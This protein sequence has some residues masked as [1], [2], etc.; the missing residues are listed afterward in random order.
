MVRTYSKYELSQTFGLVASSLSNIVSVADSSSRATGPGLAVVGAN[1]HVLTWDIKKGQLVSRW[2]DVNTSAQVT[3][4][5]KSG[6]DPDIYAV[7][8]DDGTIKVWDSRIES[9]VI[10]FNGHKSAVTT[11]AFDQSGARLASGAKD[12]DIIIWDLVAEVGL[13]KLRGHKDQV[14][15]LSWISSGESEEE[16]DSEEQ[17][18]EEYSFI[19]SASKDATIKFWDV[20]SQH[21]LE[22]HVAQSNGE[23]WAMGVT[24]DMSGC[25]TA[26][27]DGEL[28]V[29]S[30]NVQAA[31]FTHNGVD[32][33]ERP[34]VLQDRGIIFRQSKERTTGVI[35]H[36][37]AD[38]FAVYGSEKAVEVWRIRSETEVQ[39]SMQRKK[40]RKREKA[41][42]TNGDDD[43]AMTNGDHEEDQ[44]P[45]ITEYFVPYTIVRTGG[46][47][48]AI[49]WI[50][51]KSSKMVQL[52]AACGNNSIE[53]YDIIAIESEKRKAKAE[54]GSDYTRTYSI[55]S[56]GHRTDVRAVSLSS[57]DRM[58]ATASSGLL[59][60]WNVKTGACLRTLD[61]G[62]ALC[63]AFLPGDK[64]VVVG[65]KTGEIE[66]F[67]IA[68][69]TLIESI[70]A[71]EASIWSLQVHPDGKSCV[72]GGADKTAKFWNFDIVQEDI[73]GTKRTTP[74]LKLTHT[75]SLKVNDD[76][77]SLCFSPDSRLLAVATLDNTVKVFFTDTLKLFLNLYGHR[78]PAISMSISS[79]SKLIATSSADKN[80]RLWGL[81][82]GDCH[83]ALF[84]HNDSI[85]NV[86]FIQE[87]AT[88]EEG[89]FFFSAS[90][91]RSVKTWD[92]DKFEQVQKLSGHHSE[93]WALAVSRTGDFFVTA[94]HDKSIRIWN[95]TDEPI[96]L[97]E[98]RERE[99]EE[100]YE[101]TLTTS[102]D[103]DD[104]DGNADEDA[105]VAASKQT[106]ATLT[107]GEKIMEA[108]E[109]G[110]EDL[111][112]VQ[113][114]E[115]QKAVNPKMAPPQRD[116][117]FMALGFISA[118]RHVLNTFAKIP[119]AQL[120]DALLVLPFSVLPA[121]LTFIS[122]WVTKQRDVTLVCRVL[123]FMIKTHQKQIVTSRELKASLETI[124][125]ELRATLG[126]VKDVLGFNLAAL[127]C[128]EDRAREKG[129]STLEDV[130]ADDVASSGKKRAFVDIG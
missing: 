63:C 74:R 71:H 114:W 51:K 38:Y 49:D 101:S 70:Q 88:P 9:I 60:I 31:Q 105:A 1:E 6:A 125:R 120:Q 106:V 54:E 25:I 115:R 91:D 65:T 130:E 5:T 94:S 129:I 118:E 37:K 80:I 98:E 35:F 33:K 117:L 81:D 24:P 20:A 50:D 47:V 100:L 112:T 110:M 46:K 75:R 123:F 95:L 67:D 96:F 4:L 53:V 108:L 17:T 22:T 39:K 66:L 26:G 78:L 124:R 84:G 89:H 62:Y 30:V 13:F 56:P 16:E 34:R 121:L 82:F 113:A 27:N 12:T 8:Y 19:L 119:A 11:L 61:C 79:D 99:M 111:A 85:M 2:S 68:S 44:A 126:E 76:I 15:S 69:S 122:I 10:S 104:M 77:L 45:A 107:A 18:S 29:W 83:K 109:L 23:C 103:N 93:I 92:G 97:E 3:A 72:T 73:P 87:P 28:K 58:L 7:G 116:P 40:R 41:G 14:V 90:K 64:I 21:C 52:T 32:G 36:P 42:Q 57:D 55:D 102:L 86:K 127:K 43:T 48:S 128:I 59:K